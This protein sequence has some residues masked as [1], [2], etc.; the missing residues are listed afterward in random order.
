[1]TCAE[2]EELSG[3]YVLDATSLAERQAARE[4]L[5]TCQNCTRLAQE[6]RATV[7]LLPLATPQVTPSPTLRERLLQAIRQEN[8]PIPLRQSRRR[9]PRGSWAG[10]VLAVAAAVMFLALGGM[11]AW[12]VALQHQIATL[13]TST[14]QLGNQVNSLEATNA[15]QLGQINSLHHQVAQVYALAG[16]KA[17]QAVNGSLF[18]IPQQNITVMVLHGLPTLTGKQLYQ[19]WLLRNNQTVSIGT[20]SIQNGVASLTFPGAISGYDHAAVSQEPGPFPSKLS[21]AGPV[22]ALGQLQHPTGALYII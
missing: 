7:A 22:L 2:F 8:Q 13:Q 16:T 4:H 5:A 10:R 3:A 9:L 19:G 1:M 15:S 12:N 11:T 18:Y 6:L 20:L 14:T 17:P 21:P